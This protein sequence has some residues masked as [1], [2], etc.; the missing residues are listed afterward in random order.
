MN[1]VQAKAHDSYAGKLIL[2][3]LV[4]FALMVAIM[5]KI[6]NN[7]PIQQHNGFVV[8]APT[9]KTLYILSSRHSAVLYSKNGISPEQYTSKLKRFAR[10]LQQ[11]GFKTEIIPESKI[12][13]IPK[14]GIVFAVDAPALSQDTKQYLKTFLEKGGNL[15]FN[16]TTGFSDQ[17]GNYIGDEFIHD[18]TGLSLNPRVGFLSFKGSGALFVTPKILSPFSHY[19]ND[20]TSLSVILYDKVP[21]YLHDKDLTPDIYATTFSQASP[22]VS[23]KWEESLSPQEAGMG[24]HGY[25]GKGKWAYISFPTYSFY[26][27]ADQV[28]KFKKLMA[29][30][31][32]FLSH[33]VLTE[34]YPFID[35]KGGVFISEDTEYK[36][37]NFQHFADLAQEYRIP[38]TAF[39][40]ASLAQKPEYKE[41]LQNISQ[42]PYVEFA[43]HSTSHKQIVGKDAAYVKNETIGSKQII[44]Q[45]ASKPVR[46][47]RPPREELNDLMKQY[48]NDGGFVYI[49]GATKEFLYPRFDKEYSH[50]LYVPR[51]GTDDYSYLVNLDWSQQ[52]IVDQMIKEAHFVNALG[53]IYTLSVHTHLFSYG[54]NINILR[55]FFH[56]MK[57]H[58]E[59]KPLSGRQLYSRV[60][61][62]RKLYHSAALSGNQLVIT[63]TNDNSIP[64]QDVHIQLFQSPMT[65][66][67]KGTVDNPNI[68]VQVN[69]S[70]DFIQLDTIPANETVKIYLT[71]ENLQ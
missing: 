32:N 37:E 8:T 3:I 27:N 59:L 53:G 19:L 1:A 16:F 44:D 51:H 29:G 70:N 24:W 10:F 40:V 35:Q 45:Y 9:H 57:E 25:Y 52:Q 2:S 22:V 14:D 20:G 61:L 15:F 4:L 43:S 13:K 39:I 36:F 7:D 18:I 6:Q 58:P 64:V 11:T 41:M 34:I 71:L 12:K 17:E 50:L 66:I 48:L 54:T 33:K 21:F 63:L 65:R 56:Y 69:N 42:N 55:K 5:Y 26:D 62:K 46:G 31:V 47:F 28:D 30:V 60:A 38:V 23:K 68:T 67:V 49:L